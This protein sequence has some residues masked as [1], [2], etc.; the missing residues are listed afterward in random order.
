VKKS[1]K[2]TKP[3]SPLRRPNGDLDVNAFSQG[4]IANIVAFL[5]QEAEPAAQRLLCRA[6][7]IDFHADGGPYDAA[8]HLIAPT[9][10]RDGSDLITEELNAQGIAYKIWGDGDTAAERLGAAIFDALAMQAISSY[11]LGLAVG[12]RLGPQ[13]FTETERGGAQ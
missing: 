6:S 12:R 10:R 5:E 3:R 7:P 9:T 4:E 13:R 1:N 11:F 8:L 2:S